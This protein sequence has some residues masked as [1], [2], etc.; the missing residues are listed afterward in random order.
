[1][2]TPEEIYRA[3]LMPKIKE[4]FPHSD[5]EEKLSMYNTLT[6][7]L[8]IIYS[9]INQAQREAYNQALE[10]AA[11]NATLKGHPESF[12]TTAIIVD[13]ESILKLKK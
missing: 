2:K 10:D 7:Q 9:A 1:M 11:E 5:H 12:F 6:E 3:N 13:K 4:W 8:P